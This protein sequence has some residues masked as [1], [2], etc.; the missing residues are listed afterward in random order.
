MDAVLRLDCAKM[1]QPRQIL[2]TGLLGQTA[3]RHGKPPKWMSH[4]MHGD[5]WDQRPCT[6][7]GA[8]SQASR[9]GSG[10]G[11]QGRQWPTSTTRN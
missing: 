4:G 9:H 8:S 1:L 6:R 11:A 2:A 10:G 7:L 5:A 3:K